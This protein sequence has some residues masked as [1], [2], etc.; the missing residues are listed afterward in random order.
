MINNN[1]NNSKSFNN[2]NNNN[3][4]FPLPPSATILQDYQDPIQLNLQRTSKYTIPINN[5]NLNSKSK[6]IS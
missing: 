1:I 4:T 5:L 3:E 6:F 2:N